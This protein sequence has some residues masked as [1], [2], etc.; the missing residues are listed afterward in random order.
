MRHQYNEEVKLELERKQKEEEELR[1][2][3][4]EQ[5]RRELRKATTFKARPNPFASHWIGY[6]SQQSA[7]QVKKMICILEVEF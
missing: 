7:I 2:R 6:S 4:D 5:V 1:Q 3:S